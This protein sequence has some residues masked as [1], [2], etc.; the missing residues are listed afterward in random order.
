MLFKSSDPWPLSHHDLI[1]HY[2]AQ[3]DK[4]VASGEYQPF[5][6]PWGTIGALVVII[7]LL[8]PHQNRPWLKRSRY[9]AFAWMTGFATYSNLYTRT[10]AVAPALGIG[11]INAWSVA[12]V[13]AIIVCNDAQRD[14]M[15]IERI[16]GVF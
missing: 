13:G 8:V 4:A 14:F 16:E 6:Y 15:R 10:R 5:L 3:Y 7:Y 2:H 1:N 11:L 12:W 9:L